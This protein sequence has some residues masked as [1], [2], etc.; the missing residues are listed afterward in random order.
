MKIVRNLAMLAGALLAATTA[1]S[2]M[3]ASE[4]EAAQACGADTVVWV[5]LDRGRFLPDGPGRIRQG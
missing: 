3:F 4:A 5:D 2:Q 1:E